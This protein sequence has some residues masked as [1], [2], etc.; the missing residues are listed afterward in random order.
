MC[1]VNG[2]ECAGD[3]RRKRSRAGAIPANIRAIAAACERSHDRAADESGTR[4][5]QSRF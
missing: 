1:R 2:R 5:D 4:I 3:W